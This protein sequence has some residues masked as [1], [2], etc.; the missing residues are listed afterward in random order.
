MTE[1]AVRPRG[2]G[3]RTGETEAR[4]GAATR[5]RLLDAA[6]ATILERGLYRASSNEIAR[7]A[8][9]TWGVIQHHFGTREALMGAVI[10]RHADQL[11][12]LAGTKTFTSGH[13]RAR[14]L[15]LY[16]VLEAHYG[17]SDYLAWVQ[18]LIDLRHDTGTSPGIRR[19]AEEALSGLDTH[20]SRLLSEALGAAAVDGDYRAL[21]FSSMRGLAMSNLF[22]TWTPGPARGSVDAPHLRKQVELLADALVGLAEAR[23]LSLQP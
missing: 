17:T 6:L 18:I 12:Q 2:S 5:E 15:E 16:E 14:L 3:R 21:V 13:G 19:Q 8:G 10:K 22:L 4:T 11:A 20:V 23:G 1:P 7:R 9:V